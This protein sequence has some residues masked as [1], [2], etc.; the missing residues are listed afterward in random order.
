MPESGSQ[1]TRDVPSTMPYL[2]QLDGV[3]ALAILIVFAA[4]CGYSHVV[5]GGFVV[6]VFFF[7]SGYLITTL[8]RIERARAGGVSLSAFY[9]RRSLRILPPLYL[10]LLAAGALYAAGLLDWMPVAPAARTSSA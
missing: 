2:P 4:H 1:R 5:P 10:T 7:L 8:L 9:L 3:R 6:T